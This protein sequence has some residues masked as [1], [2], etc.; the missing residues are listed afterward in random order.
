MLERAPMCITT[1]VRHQNY[2]MFESELTRYT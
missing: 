2:L 1:E